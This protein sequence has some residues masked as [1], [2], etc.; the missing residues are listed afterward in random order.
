[1]SNHKEN[2]ETH[3]EKIQGNG[4]PGGGGCRGK[5]ICRRKE[6]GGGTQISFLKLH[7]GIHFIIL[8]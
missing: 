7:G 5:E 8:F 1:M 2:V 6:M 3:L 4:S